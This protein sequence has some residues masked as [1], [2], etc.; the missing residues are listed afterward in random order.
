VSLRLCFPHG[1]C[2]QIDDALSCDPQPSPALQL[3]NLLA[4]V[5]TLEA[6]AVPLRA[7][8]IE[9][10]I[11]VTAQPAV[12]N[13]ENVVPKSRESPKNEFVGQAEG[14]PTKT[15]ELILATGFRSMLLCSRNAVF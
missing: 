11:C 1:A 3:A 5:T 4:S 2:R 10:A 9:E 7:I 15:A 14:I 8:S 13:L 6:D 12:I